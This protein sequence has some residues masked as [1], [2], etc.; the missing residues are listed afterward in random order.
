[1]VYTKTTRRIGRGRGRG[2]SRAVAAGLGP[3]GGVGQHDRASSSRSSRRPIGARSS[4]RGSASAPRIESS[5]PNP[6][7]DSSYDPTEEPYVEYTPRTPTRED[8]EEDIANLS[9]EN[10]E[11]RNE[12]SKVQAEKDQVGGWLSNLQGKH[13]KLGS[14]LNQ[15]LKENE[16]LWENNHDMAWKC[17]AL[18]WER[19]II[20]R[21]W[22]MRVGDRARY[23]RGAASEYVGLIKGYFSDWAHQFR[24]GPSLGFIWKYRPDNTY[25][26]FV[27]MTYYPTDMP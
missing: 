24:Q 21:T 9:E 22:K 7:D 19:R 5:Q 3:R 20:A 2:G 13:V 12:L 27:K 10:T 4:S 17:V 14:E 16:E 26:E 25:E 1:M 15:V 11:L 6:V 8:L 18:K 23:Y